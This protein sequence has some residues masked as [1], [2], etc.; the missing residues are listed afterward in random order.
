VLHFKVDTKRRVRDKQKTDGIRSSEIRQGLDGLARLLGEACQLIGL[1]QAEAAD[2]GELDQHR[3]A[4]WVIESPCDVVIAVCNKPKELPKPFMK[5]ARRVRDDAL[6]LM[7]SAL[8]Q[9]VERDLA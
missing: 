8:T 5:R 1:E 3:G 6:S 2:C 7:E 9:T 4:L